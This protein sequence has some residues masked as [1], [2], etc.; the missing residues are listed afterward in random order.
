M[1]FLDDL[2]KKLNMVSQEVASQ[3]TAFAEQTRINAKISDEERQISAYFTQLGKTYFDDHKDDPISKYIDTIN[4]IKD[5]M[6]RIEVYKAD[7]RRAKGMVKC[8][9][10]GADVS[11]SVPYCSYCGSPLPKEACSES[12]GFKGG[13][14]GLGD[15]V[16]NHDGSFSTPETNGTTLNY[17]SSTSSFDL[18]SLDI[19]KSSLNNNG[20]SVTLDKDNNF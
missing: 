12:T 16:V 8:P 5:A 9:N 6:H 7:I 19:D 17:D 20:G 3:T 1:A 10:C 11:K 2:S 15:T 18:S 13:I 14:S 4:N